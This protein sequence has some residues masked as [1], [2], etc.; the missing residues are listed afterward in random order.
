M[1]C[2]AIILSLG[3]GISVCPPSGLVGDP[4]TRPVG[5]EVASGQWERNGARLSAGRSP[6]ERLVIVGRAGRRGPVSMP[7]SLLTRE[8]P[9]RSGDVLA[10]SSSET[11]SRLSDRN[12]EAAPAFAPE[13]PPACRALG[14]A[15]PQWHSHSH[16]HFSGD[17]RAALQFDAV[18]LTISTSAVAALPHR[19]FPGVRNRR[20]LAVVGRGAV[21]MGAF[22]PRRPSGAAGAV[23]SRTTGTNHRELVFAPASPRH[24]RTVEAAMIAH[25]ITGRVLVGAGA[26]QGVVSSF[27]R[28]TMSTQ[29]DHGPDA[30]RRAVYLRAGT[31]MRP[32]MGASGDRQP[33]RPGALPLPALQR[34]A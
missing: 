6:V 12:P 18:R 26:G 31:A 4:L 29:E 30:H 24:A 19:D 9:G 13:A 34:P 33:Q 16:L 32:A 7:L 25:P 14:F 5:S 11:S 21:F 17:H 3:L 15:A 8:S 28:F 20:T 27:W 10:A 22:V 1:G 2:A 23:A